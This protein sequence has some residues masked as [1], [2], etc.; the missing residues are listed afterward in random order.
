MYDKEQQSPCILTNNQD[1][2]IRKR[3]HFAE[4]VPG[5]VQTGDHEFDDEYYRSPSPTGDIEKA[6][7]KKYM[8]TEAAC[9]QSDS[10]DCEQLAEKHSKEIRKETIQK[11]PCNGE[12]RGCLRDRKRCI[13]PCHRVMVWLTRFQKARSIYN[14]PPYNEPRPYSRYFKPSSSWPATPSWRVEGTQ[15]H[16]KVPRRGQRLPKGDESC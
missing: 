10:P 6:E 1:D 7:E 16:K 14:R 11:E 9:E 2:R 4:P 8:L 5:A 3:N 15:D 12:K 13:Y